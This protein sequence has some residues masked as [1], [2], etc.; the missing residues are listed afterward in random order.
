MTC[1]ICAATT[2]SISIRTTIDWLST[3]VVSDSTDNHRIPSSGLLVIFGWSIRCSAA[4]SNYKRLVV[5]RSH[6]RSTSSSR[7]RAVSIMSLLSHENLYFLPLQEKEITPILR[8]TT[9][10]AWISS[11]IRID[12]IRSSLRYRPFLY[13]LGI[14]TKI[15]GGLCPRNC[16][17][18][19]FTTSKRRTRAE[20]RA[21]VSKRMRRKRIECSTSSASSGRNTISTNEPVAAAI[22]SPHTNGTWSD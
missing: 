3:I 21:A 8:S 9:A 2:S 4:S 5:I 12:T 15:R 20:C 17:I 19:S 22:S 18:G 1:R 14:H 13:T 16:R 11:S 10:V 7:I 6:K